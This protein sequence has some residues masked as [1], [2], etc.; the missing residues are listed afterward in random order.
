[1]VLVSDAGTPGVS[2][3]GRFVV[4]ACLRQGVEIRTVPGPSALA[5]ALAASGFPVAPSTFIGFAPRKG[6]AGFAAEL[7]TRPETLV[8]FEAPSR[9]ERLVSALAGVAP[10]REAAVCRELSKRFEEVRR[11]ALPQ[12]LLSLQQDPVRGEC[13]VVVGPGAVVQPH[14]AALEGESVKDVATA[15]ASRWGC[16]RRVVYQRLLAL[17]R[18]LGSKG[19]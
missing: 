11:A 9:V 16:K 8:L 15:L 2:D 14:V 19:S 6:L 4:T 3:P 5:S 18:E 12:L 13:V 1:V 7:A 10:H 17:E